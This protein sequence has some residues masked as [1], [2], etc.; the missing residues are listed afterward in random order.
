MIILG[1]HTLIGI[2]I[3]QRTRRSSLK[4]P[5]IEEE[6]HQADCQVKSDHA[7]SLPG[8]RFSTDELS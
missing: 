4:R 7:P 2:Y 8:R 3:K 1:V 5:Q 6:G